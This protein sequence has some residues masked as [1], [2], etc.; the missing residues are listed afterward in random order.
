MLDYYF[1]CIE[2]FKIINKFGLKLHISSGSEPKSVGSKP[3]LAGSASRI[4]KN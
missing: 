2:R 3:K 4:Y 1:I